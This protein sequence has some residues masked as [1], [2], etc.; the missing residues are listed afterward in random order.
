MTV[1]VKRTPAYGLW[2]AVVELVDGRAAVAVA[3]TAAAAERLATRKA[4][5]SPKVEPCEEC[6]RDVPRAVAVQ[7]A[8]SFARVLCDHCR[9]EQC[10]EDWYDTSDPDQ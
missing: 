10:G 5:K 3:L 8:V 1:M 7:S 2:L 6:G 4:E 9:A